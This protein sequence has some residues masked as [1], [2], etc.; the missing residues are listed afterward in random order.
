MSIPPPPYEMPCESLTLVYAVDP[1]GLRRVVPPA[2]D[3][4]PLPVVKQHILVVMAYRYE[5]GRSLR[6][7]DFPV[8]NEIVYATPVARG[9]RTGLRY[10]RMD[11][12]DPLAIEAGRRYYG[13][14]KFLADVR[15]D[16]IRDNVDVEARKKI[17]WNRY[18]DPLLSISAELKVGFL[19]AVQGQV[20]SAAGHILPFLRSGLLL[21]AGTVSSFRFDYKHSEAWP[22]RI[23]HADFPWLEKRRLLRHGQGDQPLFGFFSSKCTLWLEE[24]RQVSQVS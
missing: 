8:Y 20:M 11:L 22:V 23:K 3:L 14:P 12:T 19:E 9:R 5:H 6:R 24:P 16:K 10:I 2:L 15:F 18:G 13:F 4:L 1:A 21:Q 17:G 7:G